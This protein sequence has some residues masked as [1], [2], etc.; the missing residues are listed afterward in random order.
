MFSKAAW[1]GH[2]VERGEGTHLRGV[3]ERH[4]MADAGA[5]IVP[6]HVKA[7][8]PQRRHDLDLILCR[9]ALAV[10]VEIVGGGLAAVAVA[11]QVGRH[12]RVVLCEYRR[13]LVP[14]QV[15]LRIAVEQQKR[16]ALTPLHEIDRDGRGLDLR[17]G[18]A[19]EHAWLIRRMTARA[20]VCR[21]SI[22]VMPSQGVRP[23]RGRTHIGSRTGVRRVGY[24]P[25]QHL[26]HSGNRR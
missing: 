1:G 15:I 19:V 17:P 13:H 11:A 14:H 22:A 7:V 26:W 21:R 20:A 5:A 3:V 18:E 25:P 9:G 10:V 2:H 8:E 24:R 12:H 6:H 23:R 16:R 4:A